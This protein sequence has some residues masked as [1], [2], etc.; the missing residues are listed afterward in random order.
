MGPEMQPSLCAESEMPLTDCIWASS[1]E[2]QRTKR[3]KMVC[4]TA[5]GS[6]VF[7]SI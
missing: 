4:G 2:E 3:T 5:G 7:A 1:R 6:G